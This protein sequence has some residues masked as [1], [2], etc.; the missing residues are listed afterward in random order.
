MSIPKYL[1]SALWSYDVSRIDSIEHKDI[2]ISQVLNHG[3]WK[4]L[5]WLLETYD[6]KDIKQAISEPKRGAWYD[7]VLNYW[8]QVLNLEI[9]KEARQKA[10]FSLEPTNIPLPHGAT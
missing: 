3:N 2:I 7:D 5:Q 4:Q 9:P 8:E 1:Q 6:T 10:L